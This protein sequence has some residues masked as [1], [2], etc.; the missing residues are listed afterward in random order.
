M[1]RGL[2]RAMRIQN[3]IGESLLEFGDLRF[4]NPNCTSVTWSSVTI[5]ALP[6]LLRTEPRVSP[7]VGGLARNADGRGPDALQAI[8]ILREPAHFP[9][10]EE[11]DVPAAAPAGRLGAT[12]VTPG[13]QE[14]TLVVGVKGL[15]S[16]RGGGKVCHPR[17]ETP[18][19]WRRA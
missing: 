19:P 12:V 5:C 3:R 18:S 8:T 16:W 7:L 1:I 10:T 4:H 15:V 13:D 14:P 17:C 9:L 6:N 2:R 11:A